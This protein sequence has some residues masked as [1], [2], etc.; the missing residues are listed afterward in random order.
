MSFKSKFESHPVVF[1]LGLIVIGFT[2]GFASRGYLPGLATAVPETAATIKACN[3]EGAAELTKAHNIRL[4]NLRESLAFYEQ[5]SSR[6][7]NTL[8]EQERYKESGARVRQDISQELEIFKA[9]VSTL[10][11]VCAE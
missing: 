3:L 10:S 6:F 4:Q 9:S 7:S 5:Q 8:N 1:G 11:K 2:A